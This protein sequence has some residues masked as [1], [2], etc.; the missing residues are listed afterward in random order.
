MSAPTLAAE[1]E[2]LLGHLA[3]A[4]AL[5]AA[6]V[7]ARLQARIEAGEAMPAGADWTA[8]ASTHAACLK[9]AAQ[10]DGELKAALCAQEQGA[11]AARAYGRAAGSP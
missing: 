8:L 4:D 2:L 9:A 5:S 7:A 6:T 1:L 3:G 11:K 10:L